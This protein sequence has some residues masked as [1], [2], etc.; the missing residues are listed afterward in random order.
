MRDLDLF[1]F[2]DYRAFL[3]AHAQ[4]M[5][6]THTRWSFG[7]WARRLNLKATS[8]LTKIIQGER[9][10]G[11]E[12]TDK[13]IQYFRFNDSQSQYFR[14]LVR[15]HKLKNDPRLSLMLIEKIQ[16]RYSNT[17]FKV[18]DDKTFLS[19]SNW[20]YYSLREMVR[21]DFF[22]E[23]PKWI[24][25][26]HQFKVTPQDAR[27]ALDD[28][29]TLGLLKRNE[30]GELEVTSDCVSSGDNDFAT[31]GVNRY[32]EQSLRN[33]TEAIRSVPLSDREFGGMVI[34]VSSERITEA[35]HFVRDVRRKFAEL[36]DDPNG[37]RI[38][39]F[40]L[41]MFPLTKKI[42]MRECV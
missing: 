5:K 8:S 11:P 28:M 15:L 21:T 34:A 18:L 37:D 32:H 35:K 42:E 2:S 41:Q 23:D 31:E 40:Q 39:Q 16:K 12:M 6:T 26:V 36:F 7:S 24:S 20:Y 29:L 13:F 33:A 27:K 30:H 3:I 4:D 14:D 10:P 19:I 1:E 22:L 25:Q 9:N 38:Y 17:R